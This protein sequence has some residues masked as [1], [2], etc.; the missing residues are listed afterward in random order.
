MKYYLSVFLLVF[1][2]V[3]VHAQSLSMPELTNL[4]TLTNEQANNALIYGKPFK[5]LYWQAVNGI[6]IVHYRA[7]D[8]P[9]KFENI[10]IG[11]GT[12]TSEGIFLHTVTY[13]TS[14]TK[15]VLSLIAQAKDAGLNINFQG[16][17]ASNNI[18]LFD[19]SFFAVKIYINVNN[20]QGIVE[21]TQKEYIAVD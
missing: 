13:T 7:G 3:N 9:S 14:N 20:T 6:Q 2:G 10:V 11:D 21:I 18:Y 19:N 17:D 5:K 16:V 15:Y 8:L 12:K 4:A 1:V